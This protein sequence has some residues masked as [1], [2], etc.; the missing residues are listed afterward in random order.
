MR[1][2]SGLWPD[3]S[4]IWNLFCLDLL[5]WWVGLFLCLGTDTLH[6]P[7]SL[8]FQI[9]SI[10]A[11]CY[12]TGTIIFKCLQIHTVIQCSLAVHF[13]LKNPLTCLYTDLWKDSQDMTGATFFLFVI[14]LLQLGLMKPQVFRHSLVTFSRQMSLYNYSYVVFWN[15]FRSCHISL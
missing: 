5:W 13:H 14:N 4:N 12:T 6:D 11:M 2:R 10:L 1:L 9:T 3:H 8:K 7:L 15:L